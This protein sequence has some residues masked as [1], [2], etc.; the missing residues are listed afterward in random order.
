[1]RQVGVGPKILISVRSRDHVIKFILPHLG[2]YFGLHFLLLEW[3]FE[4]YSLTLSST[5]VRFTRLSS[6]P[7]VVGRN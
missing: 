2:L 6:S 3:P 7:T 4:V 1:M 5:P